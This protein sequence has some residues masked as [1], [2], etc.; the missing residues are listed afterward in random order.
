MLKIPKHLLREK[1]RNYELLLNESFHN[2]KPMV[3]PLG[4]VI[5]VSEK[6]NTKCVYCPY[7]NNTVTTNKTD[8]DPDI[9]KSILKEFSQKKGVF[10][11]FTGGEPLIYSHIEELVSE[12]LFYGFHTTIVTNGLL[13]NEEKKPFLKKLSAL[14]VSIDSLN[15]ENS[16][17]IR[18][19][20]RDDYLRCIRTL[21]EIKKENPKIWVGVNCVISK[22]NLYDIPELISYLS[23]H[24][25]NIQ[26]QP[27]HSFG[28]EENANLYPSKEDLVEII[29]NISDKKR[30]G[31]KINS[32]IWYL[33]NIIKYFELKNNKRLQNTYKCSAGYFQ[34]ILDSDLSIRFCCMLP[35]IGNLNTSTLEEI[36]NSENAQIQRKMIKDKKCPFCWLMYIDNNIENY[37]ENQ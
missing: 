22:A 12:S 19:I 35:P 17:D 7:K 11:R 29:Q 27:I 18:G 32:S 21:V 4:L 31:Y 14:T 3:N 6:C 13:V 26:F 23:K 30:K 33:E 34:I 5:S 20:S 37:N 8:I 24:K 25:I 9:V 1:T 28:D 36:W 15:A 10:I 16:V 2:I